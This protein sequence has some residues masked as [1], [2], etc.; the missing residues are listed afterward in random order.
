MAE[1]IVC[2]M[3]K[4]NIIELH[5]VKVYVYGFEILISSTISVLLIV[6]LSV[7]MGTS[8]AW[9]IFLLGFIPERVTAGGYHA[10]TPLRCHIIFSFV[11]F[12]L[13]FI[14]SVFSFPSC[15]AMLTS[16]CELILVW[17]FSPIEA[18][19]K[20]LNKLKKQNNR[21]KS[22]AVCAIDILISFF[23][24]ISFDILTVSLAV[25]FLCKWAF[26]FFILLGFYKSA[27]YQL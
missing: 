11:F 5:A 6:L 27:K 19:N 4:C 9:V 14:S 2:F 20:P 3:K 26:M 25:F 7:A 24:V 21:R 18:A 13:L 23:V 22:I 17:K 12:V 15:F 10:A 16:I 8:Y 1:A